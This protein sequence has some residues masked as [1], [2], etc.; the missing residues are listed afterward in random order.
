[1]SF[2]IMKGFSLFV[3][4]LLAAGCMP[5]VSPPEK[6]HQ[7]ISS[8]CLITIDPSSRNTL[9]MW[10]SEIPIGTVVQIEA[11]SREKLRNEPLMIR[12]VDTDCTIESERIFSGKNI[13]STSIEV[14][15][16]KG[17]DASRLFK[18]VS[19]GEFTGSYAYD[20]C[21]PRFWPLV[22]KVVDRIEASYCE[23]QSCL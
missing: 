16:T 13:Y 7:D 22:P 17:S 6:Y 12:V 19:R 23:N 21:S 9:G 3:F 8:D 10:V 14:D 1:M 15:Y 20:I 11:C 4:V 5:T 2:E 18:E